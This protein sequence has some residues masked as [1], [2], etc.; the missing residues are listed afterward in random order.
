MTTDQSCKL[1]VMLVS[2]RRKILIDGW[3][4]EM[5]LTFAS[6]LLLSVKTGCSS[7][8]ASQMKDNC[9]ESKY[10]SGIKRKIRLFIWTLYEPLSQFSSSWIFWLST[11]SFYANAD[12]YFINLIQTF[13]TYGF[14]Q[15]NFRNTQYTDFFRSRGF[16]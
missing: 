2:I 3:M 14:Y 7:E 1:I 6:S 15:V 10:L 5:K 12:N 16:G 13:C 11:A 4:S 8:I 9:V